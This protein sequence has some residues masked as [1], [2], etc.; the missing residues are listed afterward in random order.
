MSNRGK[1]SLSVL[2]NRRR[3]CPVCGK[4][5]VAKNSH[6]RLCAKCKKIV[7]RRKVGVE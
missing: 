1:W 6:I 7:G 5:F 2:A 4:P 3:T